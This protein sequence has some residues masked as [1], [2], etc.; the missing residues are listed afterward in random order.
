MG[1][2][3]L[4]RALRVAQRQFS[5]GL[6]MMYIGSGTLDASVTVVVLGMLVILLFCYV[7]CADVQTCAGLLKR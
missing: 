2:G 3:K 7:Q 6:V 5:N 4:Y 1:F